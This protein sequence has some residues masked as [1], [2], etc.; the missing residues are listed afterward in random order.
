[1]TN[2]EWMVAFQTKGGVCMEK[3]CCGQERPQ[4]GVWRLESRRNPQTGM[5]ALRNLQGGAN[6]FA[7]ICPIFAIFCVV[8]R[9]FFAGFHDA[10]D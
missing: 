4:S 3:R 2:D 10:Q 1:M 5:S 7:I 8:L 9:K 6:I